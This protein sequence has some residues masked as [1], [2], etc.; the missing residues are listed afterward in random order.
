MDKQFVDDELG[1]EELDAVSGGA[2]DGQDIID[3]LS[4]NPLI[5]AWVGM[6]C[7]VPKSK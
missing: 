5:K 7:P 6:G 3:A 1:L 4:G 2:C